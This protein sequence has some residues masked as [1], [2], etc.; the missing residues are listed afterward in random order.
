MED[1]RT[2]EHVTNTEVETPAGTEVEKTEVDRTVTEPVPAKPEPGV[3]TP[4]PA[5]PDLAEGD[6]TKAAE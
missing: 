3:D 1:K 5:D 6:D 4:V 2:E